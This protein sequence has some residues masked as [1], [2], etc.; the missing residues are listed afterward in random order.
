MSLL[1]KEGRWL[2]FHC[3]LGWL[4]MFP[5]CLFICCCCFWDRI[6]LCHS[7]CPEFFFFLVQ[8]LNPEPHGYEASVL[9][10]SYVYLT[11]LMPSK[12]KVEWCWGSQK[13]EPEQVWD[14]LLI[15]S[16]W[17]WVPQLRSSHQLGPPTPTT[18]SPGHCRSSSSLPAG[19]CFAGLCLL[20]AFLLG[21][22]PRTLNLLG[23]FGGGV[24]FNGTIE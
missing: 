15:F 14:C 23:F 4:F 12:C 7:C 16:V 5:F 17:I 19:L 8:E 9:P 10:L 6:S 2:R 22:N 20:Q 13:P 21:F 18:Q 3:S 1:V 24:V 11:L